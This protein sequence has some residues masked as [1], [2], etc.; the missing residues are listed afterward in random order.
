[1][2]VFSYNRTQPV[3]TNL[4]GNGIYTPRGRR[5]SGKWTPTQ[6]GASAQIPGNPATATGNQ[7]TQRQRLCAGVG[8]APAH[9]PPA[10]RTTTAGKPGAHLSCLDLRHYIQIYTTSE[11]CM[12]GRPVSGRR[13]HARRVFLL[14]S[15]PGAA[16]SR[17]SCALPGTWGPRSQRPC[18][19]EQLQEARVMPLRSTTVR[20]SLP[21]R[22]WARSA[23]GAVMATSRELPGHEALLHYTSGTA[24][25]VRS[26][27][28]AG[29][30]L[31]IMTGKWSL[32][33]N[34]NHNAVTR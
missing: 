19:I 26:S 6:R 16:R 5:S 27:C 25:M 33:V 29:L 32:A 8:Q 17:R 13:G 3:K 11:I 20:K 15:V 18:R 30:D 9:R 21:Y 31:C 24:S 23:S 12:C 1:M 2:H 14:I 22:A 7:P 34:S 4:H 10:M 28:T